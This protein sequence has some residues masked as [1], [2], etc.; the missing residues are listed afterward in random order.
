MSEVAE[1]EEIKRLEYCEWLANKM[2]RQEEEEADFV[3]Y[4]E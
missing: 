2:Q 1:A 3:P 4:Y